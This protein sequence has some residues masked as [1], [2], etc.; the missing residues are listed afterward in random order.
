MS[1]PV[2]S[3]TSTPEQPAKPVVLITGGAGNIGTALVRA[4]NCDYTVVSLDMAASDEAAYSEKLDLTDAGIPDGT[5]SSSDAEE[6]SVC[7]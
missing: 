3:N 4:L 5:H 1:A 2:S 7:G 6:P